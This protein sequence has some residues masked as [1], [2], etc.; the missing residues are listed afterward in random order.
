MK[1]NVFLCLIILMVMCCVGCV[2]VKT[3]KDDTTQNV[4][5]DSLKDDNILAFL[6]TNNVINNDDTYMGVDQDI[7]IFGKEGNK[8]YVYKQADNEFYYIE[9]S[10]CHFGNEGEFYGYKYKADETFYFITVMQCNYNDDAEFVSDVVTKVYGEETH[11]IVSGT[12]D[13]LQLRVA[14]E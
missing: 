5:E 1:R 9:I 6:K 7:G 14:V 11:Y 8:R 12:D 4:T 10:E 13:N 2:S 3:S